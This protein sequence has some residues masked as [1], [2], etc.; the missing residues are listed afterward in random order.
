MFLF[1]IYEK[2]VIEEII[3]VYNFIDWISTLEK[4]IIFSKHDIEK[5]WNWIEW[6]SF[7]AAAACISKST[8]ILLNF[9]K[10]LQNSKP[11]AR[12]PDTLCKM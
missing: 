3:N 6:M 10:S 5:I 1:E 8:V 11:I 7:V 2:I 9:L 4:K 12:R